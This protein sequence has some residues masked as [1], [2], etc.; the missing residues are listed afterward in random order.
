MPTIPKK[1]AVLE[2]TNIVSINPLAVLFITAYFRSRSN[3]FKAGKLKHR[4]HKWKELTSDKETLQTVMG[5]KL[6]SLGQTPVKH[7][8]CIPQFSKED[9][10]VIDL[11]IH[12]LSAKGAITKYEHETGEYISPIFKRQKP[13]G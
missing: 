7:N 12:K 10:S 5:L 6:E 1:Q 2:L 4:F 9:E 8:S 13:D 3:E 11:E